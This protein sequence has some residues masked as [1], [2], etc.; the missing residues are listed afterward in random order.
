MQNRFIE[1]RDAKIMKEKI[2]TFSIDSEI[3]EKKLE[4][5]K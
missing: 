3:K 5:I 2:E 4:S 1:L